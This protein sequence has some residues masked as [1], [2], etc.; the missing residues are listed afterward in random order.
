MYVRPLE[1]SAGDVRDGS[2]WSLHKR[3][4]NN[5]A[6]AEERGEC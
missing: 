6:E 5:K 3:I 4:G 1:S 2:Q